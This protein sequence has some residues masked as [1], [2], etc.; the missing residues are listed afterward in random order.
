M[1]GRMLSG[2]PRAVFWVQ[3]SLT[4]RPGHGQVVWVL[5]YPSVKWKIGVT[6]QYWRAP[7]RWVVTEQRS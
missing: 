7:R 2:G 3:Q 1:L 5:V 4:N 6:H